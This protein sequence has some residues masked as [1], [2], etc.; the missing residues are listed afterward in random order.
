MKKQILALG[1]A[2]LAITGCKDIGENA[3]VND[4]LKGA[5]DWV[6][7]GSKDNL[8]AT[9]SAKIKNG[10]IGFATTQASASA[11]AELAGQIATRIESKYRELTTSGEDSVN[12]EAVR[13]VRQSVDQVLTGTKVTKKWVSKDGVLWV[14][15]QVE[16]LDTKLLKDNLLQLDGLNQEAAKALAQSVDELI[17]GPQAQE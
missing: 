16:K 5:P 8:S 4:A 6:I 15:V 10:N 12:Q 11:R 17:D 1:I 7:D 2:L 14:L 3:D 9:G 13:A